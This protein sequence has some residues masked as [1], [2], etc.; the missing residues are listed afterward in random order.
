VCF[1]SQGSEA[2][3]G[4]EK[5]GSNIERRTPIEILDGGAANAGISKSTTIEDSRIR[6]QQASGGKL[7]RRPRRRLAALPFVA[8]DG[9]SAADITSLVTVDFASKA[10]SF[11]VPDAHKA[12][13]RWFENVSI[14]RRGLEGC[15]G[16]RLPRQTHDA[17][18][19]AKKDRR[20]HSEELC[21]MKAATPLRASLRICQ[22]SDVVAAGC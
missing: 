4:R 2:V 10:M 14:E 1:L 18:P 19:A 16:R 17:T 15:A 13:R 7:L 5:G 21:G 11:P 3:A 22:R 9:F 12:L 6:A 20:K 8:G